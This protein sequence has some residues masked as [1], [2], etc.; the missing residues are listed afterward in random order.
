LPIQKRL[1]KF[2]LKGALL[3]IRKMGREEVKDIVNNEERYI[4]EIKK[5]YPGMARALFDRREEYM[6][7]NLASLDEQGKVVAFVGDGHVDGLKRRLPVAKVI[8]LR[9]MLGDCRGFSYTLRF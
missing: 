7:S 5:K 3:P 1:L 6:A 2:Y 8:R 9:E 4:A